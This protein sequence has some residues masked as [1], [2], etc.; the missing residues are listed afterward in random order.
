METYGCQMN[1]A[2]S[3]TVL[4]ILRE[5]GYGR[6][7][8]PEGAAV[9]LVNTCAIREG[10]EAKVWGRLRQL[11]RDLRPEAAVRRAEAASPRP[12]VVGVL[13]CM[14]ERLKGRL[15]E[16][17]RSGGRLADLVVG[18]DAYRDL[19]LL[20]DALRR[21]DARTAMNV[22]LSLEETYADVAPVREA[23]A[24]SAFV[25]IMRGCNNMCAFCIVPFTRGRERSRAADSIV[26]EVRQLSAQGV[27]EVTLLGQN[28]NSYSDGS[29][30]P[31]AARAE[32]SGPLAGREGGGRGE[33]EGEGEGFG[34]HY[35]RGFQS[36]YLPRRRG[37]TSFAELLGRVAA[38]DPEMRVRYT[39]PHPKE[40]SDDVLDVVAR[41]PNVCM[42]LHMPAQSGSTRMLQ[43][44]RRGYSREA[45][46]ALARRIRRWLPGVALSSDFIVGFCGET[47]ADH[48]AT[49]EL[50]EEVGYEHAFIF[51]YSRREKTRAARHLQDDVPEAVKKRRLAELLEVFRREQARRFAAEVGRLH[52]VLVEGP[53]R[54]STP[55]RPQLQG[56]TCTNV[57]VVFDD[58]L[59]GEWAGPG[60]QAGRTTGVLGGPFR[61]LAPGDYAACRVQGVTSATLHAEVVGRTTLQGFFRACGTTVPREGAGLAAGPRQEHESTIAMTVA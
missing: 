61:R 25:S 5:A 32:A 13:G 16:G 15:L 34:A 26:A 50:L 39:S 54:H 48:R 4:G 33:G 40:F 43:A 17:D 19:P 7:A 57:R 36:V 8:T 45:Y 2:D 12:P 51:A 14:A 29:G 37:Q 1:V 6:A 55:E 20:V 41:H 49:V 3:E 53:S 38:V 23:G 28:V 18:P 42:Q 10:A 27:R 22:Q 31:T 47:E 30:A 58:A 9:V 52:L 46:S 44:M 21:G 56:R 59:A 11:R 24:T 60:P 35:A